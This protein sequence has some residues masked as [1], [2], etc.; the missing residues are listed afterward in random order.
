SFLYELPFGT[1]K[2]IGSNVGEFAN[3]LI[4]GWQ[5]GGVA[6]LQGGLPFT[7]TGGAGRPDRICNG[8]T[9]PEGHSVDRWFDVSCFP[10][11]AAVPDPVRG[12]VYIPFGNSGAN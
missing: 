12:G 5:L 11:P 10:L 3:Q 1:G 6:L 8:Q 4:G 7:V 2:A 9:P